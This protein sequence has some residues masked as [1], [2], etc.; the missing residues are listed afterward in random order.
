MRAQHPYELLQKWR[1]RDALVIASPFVLLVLLVTFQIINLN[2]NLGIPVLIVGALGTL[3]LTY[4]SQ[5]TIH[6]IAEIANTQNNKI[7][8]SASL[9]FDSSENKGL[10]SLQ[11]A[12]IRKLN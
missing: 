5:K 10:R 11:I 4:K 7:E 1:L 2:G 6:E 12:K 3:L 8:H 9:L